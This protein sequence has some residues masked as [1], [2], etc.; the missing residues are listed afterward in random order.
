MIHTIDLEFQGEKQSI[1]SYVVETSEGPIVIETG[2]HS[3]FPTLEKGLNSIGFA[4]EDVK[5]VFISHIHLDHAGASWVFAEKGAK[6]Y[7]HSFGEK[8]L[9][10]PEK[11]LNSAKRIY[12]DKMDELWGTLKPIPK[13]QLIIA[14][15]NDE[16]QVGDT[17]LKAL[18]TPGHAVH[19]LAW[20]MG[21]IAFS[22][23]VAGVKIDN[24]LV[25]PPCPPPDINIEDWRRSIA[26]LR[27]RNYREI[28]LTHFGRHLSPN[29][30]LDDLEDRLV[31]W[32]DWMKP[33]FDQGASPEAIVPDFQ[34]FVKEELIKSGASEEEV[35]SYDKANP[36]YMSVYG[37]LRYWKKKQSS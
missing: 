29:D 37:L 23:D 5:H 1:A 13:D 33:F 25:I 17:K 36:A 30:I 18:Y 2:P 28:Y 3:T 35:R 9:H 7:V 14:D 15:H 21:D 27:S 6:I 34:L 32:S 26:L 8:H 20:E 19:H 22:G 31:R 11:L 4:A 12:Q 10:N 16:F 24:N